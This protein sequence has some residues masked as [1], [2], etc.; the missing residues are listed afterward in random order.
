MAKGV[1]AGALEELIM[2]AVLKEGDDAYGLS[3]QKSLR[4]AGRRLELSTIY[5][6]LERLEDKGWVS[7][8]LGGA[9]PVRGGRAKRIFRVEGFGTR[10]LK[11]AEGARRQLG[12]LK[13]ALGRS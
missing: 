4:D 13:P 9:T 6:T 12:A 10:A 8:R 2:L 11:D 1:Y 7:S 5:T 3:I